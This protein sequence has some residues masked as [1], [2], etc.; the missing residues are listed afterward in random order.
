MHISLIIKQLVKKYSQKNNL[1]EDKL[2]AGPLKRVEKRK[3]CMLFSMRL[4]AK[5]L[6]RQKD[7]TRQI[8]VIF[9]IKRRKIRFYL[10]FI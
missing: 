10:F 4:T 6:F 8:G 5:E 3:V 1:C 9:A 7:T 2:L